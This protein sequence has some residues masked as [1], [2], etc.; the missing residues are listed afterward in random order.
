M[1]F[2]NLKKHPIQSG[3]VFGVVAS[4][5][6]YVLPPQKSKLTAS[7]LIGIMGG[8]Y[9]GF[10]VC[11]GRTKH[12]IQETI[13]ASIYSYIT[14][15]LLE[16]EINMNPEYIGIGIALHGVYDLLQHFKIMPYNDHVPYEYGLTCAIADMIMGAST[17][18]LWKYT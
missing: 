10:A 9:W 15:Y 3:V 6:F 4:A 2:F 17:Y 12:L 1:S 5:G 11:N 16:N 14:V 18:L 7:L 13:V 8:V